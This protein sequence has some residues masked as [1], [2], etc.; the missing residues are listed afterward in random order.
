MHR[1]P[2]EVGLFNVSGGVAVSAVAMLVVKA[3]LS[4]DD[5]VLWDRLFTA[6]VVEAN[7]A[8]AFLIVCCTSKRRNKTYKT[9]DIYKS[10]C[11]SSEQ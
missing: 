11:S 10:S 7:G 4:Q 3:T 5:L 6:K 9:K 8:V 2:E 1:P